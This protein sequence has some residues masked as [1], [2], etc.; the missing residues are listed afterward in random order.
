MKSNKQSADHAQ[1][2]PGIAGGG[3]GGL[4]AGAAKRPASFGSLINIPSHSR[5]KDGKS[6]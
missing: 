1:K 6:K 4:A 2:G 3:K 5:G